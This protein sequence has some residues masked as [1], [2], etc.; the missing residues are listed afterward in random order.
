MGPGGYGPGPGYGAAMAAP[1]GTPVR[2]FR[3]PLGAK[4]GLAIGGLGALIGIGAAVMAVSWTSGVG[5]PS[6]V[7]E[8]AAK[9]CRKMAGKSASADNCDNY[10]KQSGP[11]ADKVCE[12]SLKSWKES[13]LCK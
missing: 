13:K 7:C 1:M 2:G 9:C 3:M 11:I 8:K 12:E 6:D 10:T 5:G 4:I